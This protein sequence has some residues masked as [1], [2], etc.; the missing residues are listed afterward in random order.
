MGV[1]YYQTMTLSQGGQLQKQEDGISSFADSDQ[2]R[3]EPEGECAPDFYNAVNNPIT[4]EI[5]KEILTWP[6]T[7]HQGGISVFHNALD[8]SQWDAL[9]PWINEQAEI[10]HNKRWRWF[11]DENGSKYALNED[12]NKFTEAE[13]AT[14]P[15]RML[16]CI[17]ANGL[18]GHEP[19]PPEFVEIFRSW[20]ET[21]YKCLMLYIDKYPYII[22]QLWWRTRGHFMK[23]ET[24][25]FLGPHA[26][27]DS[28][29]RTR[30]GKRYPP[31]TEFPTRQTISVSC[32]LNQSNQDYKG[33]NIKFPYYELDLDLS[34]G[35]V[36][37]FPANF[38]GMHEL[39]PV[40]EGER[41]TY[42]VAFGQG[43]DP[44]NPG[45]RADVNE[46]HE[47]NMWT[48]PAFLNDLHD[49][50]TE[51]FKVSPVWDNTPFFY[52]PIGQNRPLE[53]D[54]GVDNSGGGHFADDDPIFDRDVFKK[55]GEVLQEKQ[56]ETNAPQRL[57][58]LPRAES[59]K[60][61]R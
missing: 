3:Y 39:M 18:E 2:Q 44:R 1:G 10:A 47:V 9:E 20:E 57:R 33:G 6:S 55:T 24:T 31:M 4:P 28:N 8:V 58:V 17:N 60:G 11:T 48:P 26:D 41:H 52:N 27:C 50:Y 36:V 38:M 40:T 35:D 32:N 19:T 37:M 14:A 56:P 29:Y 5:A 7:H 23:Y 59:M 34:A 42:L 16:Y 43:T 54:E 30:A 15:I 22:N 49:D 61:K 25:G 13:V 53:G 45:G 46:P 51:V 21:V 12:N